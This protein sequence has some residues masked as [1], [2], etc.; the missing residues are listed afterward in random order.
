MRVA[1]RRVCVV[2]LS[3]ATVGFGVVAVP[4]ARGQVRPSGDALPVP[5]AIP[6]ESDHQY[7][8]SGAARPFLVFW[9]SRENVG[10]ARITR[11]RMAD[12]TLG[13]ELLTG[14]DPTR[15]PFHT[16]RWGYIREVV[17]GDEE[18]LIAVKSETEEETIDEARANINNGDKRRLLVFIRE[19]VTAQEAVAWS[20]VADIGREVTY[21]DLSYVL[22][23]MTGLDNW[24][25][26]RL[27]RP[28]N[29]RP[30]Y[31][32]AFNELMNATVQA[33]TAGAPSRSTRF[34]GPLVYI[35]RAKLYD[36]IQDQIEILAH[37]DRGAHGQIPAVRARFRIRSHETGT[38]SG[39]SVVVYGL[40]GDLAA[41]PIRMTYQPRWWLRTELAL[42]ESADFASQ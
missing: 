31:L 6:I 27:V 41:V 12:G 22:N 34:P 30:G 13:L 16:N 21:R 42:N 33:V 23:R 37:F 15:A 9:I 38:T 2:L 10:G 28:A 35:H 17:R 32:T 8:V 40:K 3:I 1:S 7:S 4:P 18:E 11:R 20:T 29:V 24:Q 26:R 25:Q 36:L 14:S 19:K 39:E 5:E